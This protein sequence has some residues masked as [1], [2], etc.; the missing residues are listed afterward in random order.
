MTASYALHSA[1]TLGVDETDRRFNRI[2]AIT[3]VVFLVLSVAIQFVR[4]AG[5]EDGVGDE[6]SDRYA[7]SLIHI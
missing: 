7:L 6:L 4:T 5:D 2:L 1:W 3:L